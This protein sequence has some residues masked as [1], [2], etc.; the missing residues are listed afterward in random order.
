MWIIA[1]QPRGKVM[2]ISKDTPPCQEKNLCG[3]YARTGINPNAQAC[4]AMAN[5]K[6]DLTP[7]QKSGVKLIVKYVDLYSQDVADSEEQE[8]ISILRNIM[9]PLTCSQEL[10]HA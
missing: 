6:I 5:M 8:A 3:S 10:I 7:K 4:L 2:Q 1:F 9:N